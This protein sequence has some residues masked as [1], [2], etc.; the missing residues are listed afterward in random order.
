MKLLNAS[1][2][3]SRLKP[4][5]KFHIYFELVKPERIMFFWLCSLSGVFLGSSFPPPLG[6]ILKVSFAIVFTT[7]GIYALNDIC[8][9]EV[10]RINKPGR[11]IPSGRISRAEAMNLV[12]AFSAIGII[13][14][15][16]LNPMSLML[17]LTYFLL[18]VAYSVDPPKLK[19][20]LSNYVCMALG[21]GI[22]VLFGASAVQIT[23]K[24]LFGAVG[25]S[26]FLGTCCPIKD[27]KD[28]EGDRV[29]GM[30]TLPVRIG[31]K[32][33][34]KFS[35]VNS[36]LA[37]FIFFLGYL[38]YSFSP[39]YPLMLV[40]AAII[41]GKNLNLMRINYKDRA[42]CGHALR[43]VISS[44]LIVILALILGSVDY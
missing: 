4:I 28:V 26:F 32:K 43:K 21:A 44:S 20:G 22:S 36:V 27:L 34:M 23:N 3:L 18:G 16:T 24:V 41:Y 31:E 6:C 25:M 35:M 1:I 14:A 37:F 17:I 2:S 42:K 13:T 15:S 9:E 11:P 7:L 38:F 10:D 30:R 8:D 12:L 5:E 40:V 29:M 39:L 19:R 33:T